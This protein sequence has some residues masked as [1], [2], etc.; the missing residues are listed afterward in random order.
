M[1][2]TDVQD[3]TMAWLQEQVTT[4]VL[5]LTY[6]T[7]AYGGRE[8]ADGSMSLDQALD[9]AEAAFEGLEREVTLRA[10]RVA[11]GQV[12]AALS[13]AITDVDVARRVA[14][15]PAAGNDEWNDLTEKRGV[16]RGLSRAV[17]ELTKEES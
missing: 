1:V 13:G 10:R 14:A 17:E 9:E 12:R 3:R 6:A 8:T 15:S 16:A 5:Y 4:A 2:P 7:A 11:V